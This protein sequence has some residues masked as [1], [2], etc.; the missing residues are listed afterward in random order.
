MKLQVEETYKSAFKLTGDASA[1]ATLALAEALILLPAQTFDVRAE[2][3]AEGKGLV[4]NVGC[5]PRFQDPLQV[6]VL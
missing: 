1:A 4:L 6:E 5:D 3:S 2:L